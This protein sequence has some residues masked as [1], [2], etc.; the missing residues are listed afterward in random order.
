MHLLHYKWLC[1]WY[2]LMMS[3]HGLAK[4]S[5]NNVHRVTEEHS[6]QLNVT[7]RKRTTQS[8]QIVVLNEP[9]TAMTRDIITSTVETADLQCETPSGMLYTIPGVNKTWIEQKHLNHELVSGVTQIDLPPNTLID[10]ATQTLLLNSEPVLQRT[11]TNRLELTTSNK[12]TGTKTVLVVRVEA[13]D[14]ETSLSEAELANDVF[15]DGGD[16]NNLRSQYSAC[17]FGKFELTKAWGKRGASTNIQNGIVT[18]KLAMSK[19]AGESAMLNAINSELISQFSV[20][21]A[22][23]LADFVMLCL[24]PGVM[25]PNDI[26]YGEFMSLEQGKNYQD[27]S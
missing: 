6:A 24:P 13:T 1:H 18:V 2:L 10:E 26:A 5:V 11:V 23:D 25:H 4:S 15:G 9:C 19:S 7:V 22:S 27:T 21:R 14:T 16:P 8:N 20:S 12:A 3:S 17:S